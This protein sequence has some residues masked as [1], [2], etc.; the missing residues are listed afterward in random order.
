[1]SRL[2]PLIAL[3]VASTAV[4]ACGS[5]SEPAAPPPAGAAGAT[6]AAGAGSEA[7]AAGSTSTAPPEWDRQVTAPAD[8]D[9]AQQRDACGYKKGALPKETLGTSIPTG[10]DIPIDTVVIA[11]M[12]NRSFDHYFQK[13][14]AAGIPVEVA[15]DDFSNPDPTGKPVTIFRDKTYCIADPAH[16]WTPVHAQYNGG[17]MDGFVKTNAGDSE[18]LACGPL[19]GLKGDRAMSYYEEADVP[20]T[21]FL[22]RNFAVADH[23][24][25]SLLGPTW[26]NRMY[27]YAASSFGNTGNDFPKDYGDTIFDHLTTRGVSWK[28]YQSTTPGFAVFLE[29]FLK[30]R[31]TNVVPIDQYYADAAAG[32]LPQVA[33]V[34]PGIGREGYQQNDEHPPAIME[35]GQNWIG[36]IVDALTKSPQWKR[37]A[38]F[39]TYDEHGGFYDHVVPPKACPPDD[40]VDPKASPAVGFDQLGIRVPLMVVSPYVKKGFVSHEVYDHTSITRF[41]EA[42]F[43]LPALSGRDANAR[44][45]MDMFDFASPPNATPPAIPIPPVDQAKL[46]ACKA[47]CD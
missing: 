16:G 15:P 44:I 18:H 40:R 11:M 36:K 1:M 37:S 22:A 25:C 26:P 33:F 7:G 39:I 34:D 19:T 5:S 21:Y 32:T 42:R 23:Y 3:V 24:H 47:L 45:P 14:P 35:V 17:K 13:A 41:L 9:A 12:E 46:D 31:A 27:L 8:A 30:Y 10:A 29:T 4:V 38:M 28:V 20:L 2:S 6:G 43:T